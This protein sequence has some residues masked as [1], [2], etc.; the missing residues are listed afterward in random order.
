[1]GREAMVKEDAPAL[2]RLCLKRAWP[3]ESLRH[4]DWLQAASK[5]PPSEDRFQQLYPHDRDADCY[6]DELEHVYYIHGQRYKCSA[7]GVWK[8]F[9]ADFDR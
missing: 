6:M 9:F 7:T 4:E 5:L 1:M 2:K 3:C 8:V